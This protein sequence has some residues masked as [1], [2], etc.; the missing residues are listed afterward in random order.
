MICIALAE[1]STG[2]MITC[3][4]KF[5]TSPLWTF[6]C[7]YPSL[8]VRSCQCTWVLNHIWNHD[9]A[10]L[11]TSV[12][13]QVIGQWNFNSSHR[14]ACDMMSKSL[15]WPLADNSV[16]QYAVNALQSHGSIVMCDECRCQR[17]VI[18]LRLLTSVLGFY[19]L[20]ALCTYFT[21]NVS[22][23]VN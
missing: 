22:C 21:G 2:W 12:Y 15:L 23:F 9:H 10:I 8:A 17:L 3:L 1:D 5:Q 7:S 20:Y 13:C 11:W 19:A 18:R 4:R 6:I 16:V 14:R